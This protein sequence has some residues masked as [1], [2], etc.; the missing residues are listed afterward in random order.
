MD[1]VHDYIKELQVGERSRFRRRAHA[2]MF[3]I[4]AVTLLDGSNS[5]ELDFFRQLCLQVN[6]SCQAFLFADFANYATCSASARQHEQALFVLMLFLLHIVFVHALAQLL[7]LML[8]LAAQL[9]GV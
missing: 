6:V 7:K 3:F 8:R 5:A 9:F 2:V 4:T 1:D